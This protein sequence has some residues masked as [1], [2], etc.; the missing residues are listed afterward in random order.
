MTPSSA[1]TKVGEIRPSQL[2]F[3]YGVGANVDLPNIS[4]MVMGLDDWDTTYATQ[5]WE[6]RLLTAVR[7]QLG[8]QV[9]RLFSPPE[10]PESNAFASHFDSEANVGVPVAPFPRWMLCPH[11]PALQA[12]RPN[13]IRAVPTQARPVPARPHGLRPR[14]VQQTRQGAGRAPLTLSV[15]LRER[16]PG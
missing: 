6:E 1:D 3:S 7:Q 2:L 4:A 16:A 8:E 14:L 13:Q 15:G 10:P 9:E 11:L 12:P 5:I